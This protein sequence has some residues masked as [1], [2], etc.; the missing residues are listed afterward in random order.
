MPGLGHS[1]EELE[2]MVEELDAEN[3]RLREALG[4]AISFL[5][6][7]ELDGSHAQIEELETIRTRGR[8]VLEALAKDDES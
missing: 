5:E 2:R 6:S 1:L 8:E 4:W 7:Y 3:R